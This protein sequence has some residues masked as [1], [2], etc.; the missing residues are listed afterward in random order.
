VTGDPQNQ[1][2]AS[3]K[4]IARF[5]GCSVR[6]ARRWEQLEG[7]PVHRHQH[8]ARASVYA[9]ANELAAW[10]ESRREAL[11]TRTD[12]VV[13]ELPHAPR[14]DI[15]IAVLPLSFAGADPRLS[16]LA[17]GLTDE[18]ISTLS[19][20]RAADCLRRAMDH[21]FSNYPYIAQHHP[22]FR[23]PWSDHGI[24]TLMQQLLARWQYLN[25]AAGPDR[26]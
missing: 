9:F 4:A 11:P 6:S 20:A 12:S 26:G 17:D 7:L 19:L 21:G 18:I 5:L 25:P 8:S 13:D 23:A 3:W 10:R 1:R 24:D 16:Y 15:A 22:F 14:T 2:L